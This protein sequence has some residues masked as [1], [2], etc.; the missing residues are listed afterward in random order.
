MKKLFIGL[1]LI[2]FDFN[3]TIGNCIIGITPDFIG[4]LLI[5]KGFKEISPYT[6][7]YEQTEKYSIIMIIFACVMYFGDLIGLVYICDIL[8]FFMRIIYSIGKLFITYRMVQGII[9]IE[10]K[11]NAQL[12]GKSLNLLWICKAGV[13]FTSCLGYFAPAFAILFGII[14]LI[15]S[16]AFTAYFYSAMKAFEFI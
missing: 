2:L 12:G 8:V 9:D 1:I 3:F 13:L 4:F 14:G 15:V 6:L 10:R 5:Y 16:I 11:N 7:I